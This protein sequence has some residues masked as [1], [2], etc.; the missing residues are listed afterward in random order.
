MDDGRVGECGPPAQLLGK[1]DGDHD[2][3]FRRLVVDSGI[4]VAKALAEGSKTYE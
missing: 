4:D 2:A 1:G 3:L